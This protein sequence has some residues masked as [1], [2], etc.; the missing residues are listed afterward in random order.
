MT[1]RRRSLARRGD[2]ESG[3]LSIF[4]AMCA[5]ML[6][7]LTG[8]VLDGGGRLRAY[9]RADALAQEAA[10]AGG[11]QIN[12]AALLQGH[13]LQL[14][15]TAAKQQALDYL[16]ANGIDS[17]NVLITTTGNTLIKVKFTTTYHTALLG[18]IGF[19]QLGVQGVGQAR[20]VPGVSKAAAVPAP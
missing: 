7:M 9:E 19:D 18:L 2:A 12:R 11:Q 8:L 3:T 16:T 1:T 13:G 6:L 10:R 15:T 20:L 17:R 14:D 4:V 5:T